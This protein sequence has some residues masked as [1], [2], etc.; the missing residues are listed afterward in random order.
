MFDCFVVCFFPHL[1]L[2]LKRWEDEFFTV[3]YISVCAEALVNIV[4]VSPS[5]VRWDEVCFSYAGYF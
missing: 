4:L 5:M 1:C 2:V 3:Q